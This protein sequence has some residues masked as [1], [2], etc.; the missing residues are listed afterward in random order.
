MPTYGW[1][2]LASNICTT[3][4][5]RSDP[6]RFDALNPF[7]TTRPSILILTLSGQSTST[8]YLVTQI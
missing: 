6:V 2:A 1:A 5:F 8:V 3:R 7:E 4:T